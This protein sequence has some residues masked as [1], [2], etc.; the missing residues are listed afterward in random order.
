[1][2]PISTQDNTV[3]VKESTTYPQPVIGVVTTFHPNQQT[4]TR[5]ILVSGDSE[6][7]NSAKQ[8]IKNAI[9][10]FFLAFSASKEKDLLGE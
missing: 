7:D 10:A 5:G 3:T 6:E 1:M 4:T 2:V 8:K 9:Q